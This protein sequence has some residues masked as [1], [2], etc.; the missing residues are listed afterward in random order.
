MGLDS[1]LNVMKEIK[2]VFVCFLLWLI[3]IAVNGQQ[4]HATIYGQITT[5]EGQPIFLVNIS[6]QDFSLG[7][8]TDKNGKYELKIPA[9]QN[10]TIV[11]SCMG[12][13]TE[14]I[15][16]KA[17]PTK[18][19]E[20]N[21]KLE[22]SIKELPEVEIKSRFENGNNLVKINIKH[23]EVFP[24]LSRNI[25]SL[26]K[27]F[28][29]VSSSNELSSQYSVRGGNFDENLVY[30]NDIEI[31]RPFLIRSGQQEGLSFINSDLV[32]SIKFSSGGF[33]A[34][35]GDKMSSVLDIRYIKPTEFNVSTTLSLLGG[36][37]HIEGISKNRKFTH[38]SG[39]RYKTSEYILNTLET[40]GDYQPFFWDF[41]TYWAYKF[42]DN[43]EI[44]FLG[45]Y[46]QNKYNFIPKSRV[47]SFGT[48]NDVL[49]LKIYYEGQEVDKFE[50]CLGAVSFIFQPGKK[51]SLKL[52]SSAFSTIEEETF[53]ILGQ[54]FLNELDNAIGSENY[55]DSIMNLGIGS[56]LNH[57]RNYLN[58]YVFSTTHKGSFYHKSNK[59]TWGIKFQHE[60]VFDDIIQWE[61]IDSAGYS[62]PYSDSIVNLS[63]FITANS[64]LKS[65]RITSYF[66]NTHSFKIKSTNLNLT[67]GIRTNYWDYNKQFL[68]SPR[69]SVSVIPNW[70]K[71]ITFHFASGYYYQPPFYKELRDS[72]GVLNENI[73]AQKS[74]HF[75][76]SCD[77]VFL[78]W[79]RPFKLTTEVYYKQ[80][81]H[82]IPYKVD[83]VRIRYSAK[84]NAKGYAKG[85]DLKINGEFVKG[86]ESWASLSIMKTEEDMEDDFYY[87]SD[88]K[89]IEPGYYPRPTDQLLNFSLFFQDYLP[90]NPSYKVH[91]SLFYGGKLPFTSPDS[92]RY[93][94]P[95]RMP[96]YRRVDIG[97]SK[98]LKSEET[99]FNDQNPFRFFKSVWLCA[100]VFNLLDINNIISYIWITTVSQQPD[101]SLQYAVP[102]YLT[103]RRL[104][105]RLIAKF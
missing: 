64:Q 104:N 66:Q 84:N 81:D 1:L 72:K 77:H 52:I 35:Y 74:I 65:N 59:L 101:V 40:K 5:I 51:L 105:I 13:K 53:D 27:T 41:Q 36:S 38:I 68:I 39:F 34:R 48:L 67:S 83:N 56:F 70:K 20:I 42:S 96:P 32:S 31:Y 95:F 8:S 50:T 98:V 22:I 15:T 97:F 60:E 11:F 91:L 16:F 85:I 4:E 88:N 86:V 46:A 10:I 99:T 89:R 54:Y 82:L 23:F 44:S 90:N 28:P 29:G 58:A 25:E 100:E 37:A 6:I 26:L 94:N 14:K 12:Y 45:N 71:D 63:E 87:S 19:I 61:M 24:D 18:K 55:G 76:V 92:E 43:F 47:T 93:D 33:D 3:N 79:N 2:F 49:N 17:K 7:T 30:V 103:S 80:F 75:V 21:K 9:D 69:V 102:N 62:I 73:K 57:A 78:A